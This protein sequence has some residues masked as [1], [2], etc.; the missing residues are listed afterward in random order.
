MIT[1]DR[2]RAL[3]G[4]VVSDEVAVNEAI[5]DA[6]ALLEEFL[7]RPMETGEHT[8]TLV[9]DRQ[10]RL[11]PRVTPIE[12]AEGWTIEGLA[13]VGTRLSWYF[14]ED[15]VEVTYTGGWARPDAEEPTAP[16]LPTCLQRDIAQGAYRLLHPTI[17]TAAG[18]LPGADSVRLGDAAVSGKGLGRAESTDGWWSRQSRRYRYAPIGTVT[19]LSVLL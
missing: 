15:T 6:Q 19:P 9:P 12:E 3:T 14:G 18:V 7:G 13:L 16:V 5:V 8:D 2:Y 11:W 17:A 4:D 1:A 10:G